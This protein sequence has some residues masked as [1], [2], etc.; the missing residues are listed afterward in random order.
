VVGAAQERLAKELHTDGV[1][2]APRASARWK[3]SSVEAHQVADFERQLIALREDLARVILDNER[4][5]R[6]QLEA[7]EDAALDFNHPAD[8]L[9]GDTD[10]EKELALVRKQRAELA[11]V[12][13]A[14][15]RLHEGEFGACV[16]CGEDIPL[17]RLQA[18]PF[19]L[20]CM[21]CAS[22]RERAASA[23]PPAKR[24][25][26]LTTRRG[27]DGRASFARM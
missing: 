6:D 1:S 25:A 18:M 5:V 23:P 10:Y 19:A 15:G 26:V 20:H 2:V 9:V 14:L 24:A 22:R 4:L 16:Q 27:S 3:E 17:A 13:A 8:G 7:A 21:G 12:E 11:L